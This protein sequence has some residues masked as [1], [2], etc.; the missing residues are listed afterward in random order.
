MYHTAQCRGIF[1]KTSRTSFGSI[2]DGTSNTL[3]FSESIIRGASNGGWGEAGGYWGGSRWGGYGF[4]T[5]E[6]PNTT[7]AD[8]VYQCKSTTWP[9]A[10]CISLS[11]ADETQ[12]FA[13]SYHPGGVMAVLADGS[14]RLIS[15]TIDLVT[16]RALGTAAQGEVLGE[17]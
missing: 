2:T 12:N 10:P 8:K 15:N 14:T 13:R 1:Y 3:A 11:G 6:A 5:L 4:T 17:Y 9:K 16:Y 7:V